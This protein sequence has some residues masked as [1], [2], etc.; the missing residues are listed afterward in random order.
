MQSARSIDASCRVRE[1]HTVPSRGSC[2]T[3]EAKKTRCR[4]DIG[5]YATWSESIATYTEDPILAFAEERMRCPESS[6][7]LALPAIA[8]AIQALRGGSSNAI[9]GKALPPAE[10][11]ASPC[12]ARSTGKPRFREADPEEEDRRE[13]DAWRGP[14]QA[15]CRGSTEERPAVDTHSDRAA[16]T[17]EPGG[18]RRQIATVRA[19]ARTST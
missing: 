3:R 18:R 9:D 5:K 13:A 14:A 11:R 4:F 8:R 6:N 7:V 15:H 19:L 16:R 17:I 2:S 1:R 12:H 10:S